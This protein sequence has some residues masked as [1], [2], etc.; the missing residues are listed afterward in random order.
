[1]FGKTVSAGGLLALFLFLAPH[2]VTASKTSKTMCK[3]LPGDSCYPSARQWSQFSSTLSHP[4]ISN[5]RPLAS[6]C[7]HDSPNFSA[8]ACAT[9][10]TNENDA[11]YLAGK[12]NAAQYVN[13]EAII[14][15]SSVQDC[16]YDT[17]NATTCFQGRVPPNA[18]NVSTVA[19]IQKAV[20]FA[21]QHNLRLV[22]RN[23][24]H[25][26]MGRSLGVGALEVFTHNL[27]DLEFFDNF[28]PT[29]APRGTASQFAVTMGTGI[30]WNT[31]Y[32]ESNKHNRSLPGGL[33]PYGTVGAAGGW[34]LG[35]GHSALSRYFGLGVDNALQ[36]TVV[37]P[38]GTY[39]TANQF[40]NKDLFWHSVETHPDPPYT[41]YFFIATG[42]S[43]EAYVDLLETWNH[44]HNALSD[45]GWSGVWPFFDNTLFLTMLAQNTPP[46]PAA[47]ATMLSFVNATSALPVSISAPLYLSKGFGFNFTSV[48]PGPPHSVT[49]SWLLPRNLTAPSNAR[50]L[51]EIYANLTGGVAYMVG[52]GPV[53]TADP[54]TVALT[55]AWRTIVSDLVLLPTGPGLPPATTAD[56]PAIRQALFDQMQVF[57]QLAPPPIGGQYLNEPDYLEVNWQDAYWGPNYPRLLSIKKSIDPNDLLI[58]RRGVN[59]EAWDDEIIC[60]TIS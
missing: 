27:Q 28:V 15:G 36:F 34:Q 24:G 49:S 48:V 42:N 3:C 13:F 7:Y 44:Y 26:L 57:R 39:V 23:S 32:S 29:G 9:A 53:A 52:G 60:K 4:L 43:T 35:G 58:V 38:N 18:V 11:I 46:S 2:V 17:S 6:V 56:V 37:L 31:A 47:N 22:V 1:M 54:S 21:S 41:A 16:P 50:Q 12:S 45:A 59:S 19:D 10:T 33:S 14:N 30:S 55:P 40:I 51:A 8:S 25:E 5:Q 20:R